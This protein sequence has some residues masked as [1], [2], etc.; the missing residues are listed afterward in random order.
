VRYQLTESAA[1]DVREIIHHIRTVQKSPR[2]ARLVATRLTTHFRKL[3]AM[4]GLGH[5][6]EEL[7]DPSV[8]VSL[9]TG[10]LVI[11]DPN[12]KPLLILRVVHPAR[13]LGRIAVRP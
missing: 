2:N 7:E 8:R 5:V 9:V 13:D 11:Y 1:R 3:A 4:P 6:R 10:L 12:T